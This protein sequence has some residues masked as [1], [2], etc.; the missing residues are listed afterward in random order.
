MI[1]SDS[2]KPFP[3]AARALKLVGLLLIVVAL[4]DFCI[5][6]I[7]S[8]LPAVPTALDKL[9]WQVNLLSQVVDRG[10]L[11]LMGLALLFTGLW[12]DNNSKIP[13]PRRKVWLNVKFLSLI[14]ASILGLAFLLLVP[15]HLYNTQQAS[16]ERLKQ[17][18]EGVTQA[19]GQ[20]AT[21]L[22]A[23]LEQK[24]NQINVIM[25]LDENQLQQAIA[26]GQIPAA[27]APLVQKF[28]K[29]PK[30]IDQFLDSQVQ[31]V[32]KQ[33]ETQIQTQRK[34]AEEQAKTEALRSGVRTGISS[35]LLAIGY[36]IIGWTG[37]KEL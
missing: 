17:I 23:E 27:Q 11:P 22:N 32:K 14:L 36:I 15:L 1:D 28:K 10:I 12:I 21:R 33:V 34:A 16:T 4:F 5:L 3:L 18:S 30:A 19:E 35:L 25:Q 24:R 29:D 20:L 8:G 37:L 7:P 9:Q 31:E 13:H 6:L 26:S 2:P